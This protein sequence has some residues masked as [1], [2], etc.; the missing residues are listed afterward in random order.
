MFTATNDTTTPALNLDEL[1][2]AELI[3]HIHETLHEEEPAVLILSELV[4]YFSSKLQEVGLGCEKVNATRLKERILS[5]Y[6]DLTA[7]TEGRDILLVPQNEIG[8]LKEAK[9]D[10][11]AQHLARAATIIQR[12]ILQIKNSFNG[13]FPQ[14]CQKDSIPA[15]LKTL[16][17]MIVKGSNVNADPA[18]SQACL[19]IAQLIVFNSISRYRN[20][21]HSTGSTHHI[22]SREC[23]LPI[24]AA[25]K[26]HGTTRDKSLVDTFYKLGMCISY[27]RLL[28]IST[29]IT[30]TVLERYEREQVVCPSKLRKGL[31]TTGAVDNIDHNPSSTT[32]KDSFHGTAISLVQHPTTVSP[33]NDRAIDTFD[34]T[35]KSSASKKIAQLP[36]N[37]SEVPPLTLA[38]GELYAPKNKGQLI[39]YSQQFPNDETNEEKDWLENAKKLLSK[40]EIQKNDNVS[41][42]AYRATQTSLSSHEPA[43]ISL[44]PMFTENAHSLAMI[45]HS[46]RVIRAAVA[47][48]NPSQTPVIAVD[49]PLFALAKEI[50]WRLG[51]VYDED[52][53]V[54]ML[55][56]LHVEMA[57]WKMLGKWLTGTGWAETVCSAGVVT[58]GV[59]ESLLTASHLSRTRRA[60]QVT[61]ICLYILMCRAYQE[62]ASGT[63]ENE[64]VKTFH[65]WKEDK[66]T[67][68]PQFLYWSDAL[69]LQLHC[70]QLVRAL[71]EADFSLYVKAIKLILPWMFALDHPNYARWLSVHYR[72]MCGLSTK[73]PDV[74]TQ[75]MNGNFVVH[76]TKSLFSAIALDHAH[77]QVN[78]GVKG[79]GGA[80]GLTENPAALRRW[81]V[82]GP[83][84]SRMIAEFEGSVSSPVFIVHGHHEQNPGFQ[85]TF[86]TDVLHLVASFEELGNPFSEEGEELMAIHSKEIMDSSVVNTVRNARKIGEEQFKTFM[87]ERLVER[88]KPITEPIKK[89][90]L[91]TFNV[92]SKKV[93][94]KDKAKVGVLKQDLALFSRLYI[95]CQ[96]RDGNLEEFF[97]F[98][99]QPWPPSLSETGQLR[100][101]QKADLI[102][103]LPNSSNQCTIQ[104]TIDAAIL[105]GAVIVQMLKPGTAQT[106]EDYFNYVFAPYITRQLET[107]QRVDVVWDVYHEDSLKRCT[108][109]KRGYGRRRK[110]LAS[111]RIP[112]DWKGFLRVDGNKDE[113][114]KLLAEKVMLLISTRGTIS[115][116]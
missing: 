18:E 79:E 87:N 26:I 72:D 64:A 25:L 19:T 115:K 12:D 83:E 108:R 35:V 82:A 92:H 100:G 52:R 85:N 22:R 34:P 11:D 54:F 53:F 93:V 62:Y 58:Q 95:S 73:H 39:S 63:G 69:D 89:N 2:F 103:C 5:A 30:N 84:L 56:G 111:T 116:P 40:E 109:E 81:M 59:A 51:G 86:A 74:Y 7:H 96:T 88:N 23:P 97:K 67:R 110:V 70:L 68:C 98:E 105:D 94:S 76:K 114:F 10:S 13:T 3:A 55:G 24:Y 48:V 6:P 8:V 31:F 46:M 104:P 33:G 101:G 38:T 32:C 14:E 45:A 44:L 4:K 60:H 49:Q 47:H 91:P 20:G 15:S 107:V 16:I 61:M 42:A 99:N 41:W 102:K 71:R 106:F 28:S 75:F 21:P 57:S 43:I 78:A 50:Q 36:L 1:A 112:S 9:N 66:S 37:Y 113:L 90:N 65:E 77:E 27:D 17:S 80:V 29:D